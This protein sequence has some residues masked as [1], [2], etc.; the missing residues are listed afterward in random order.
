MAGDAIEF[1]VVGQLPPL[2][3]EAKSVLSQ[4]HG[5]AL[6]VQALLEVAHEAKRD[7]NF[8][9]FDR[10]RIGMGLVVRTPGA[11]I[12][13]ATNALGGVGGSPQARRVNLDLTYLGELADAFLYDDD[14]A[15]IRKVVYREE[16]GEL[17]YRVRF[18][19]L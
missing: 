2:K 10:R 17:G 9:G 14:D 1:E 18:W 15:Q 19:A 7:A 4:G 6:R 12:G 5:Q 11:A 8:E 3:G 16:A 13:D